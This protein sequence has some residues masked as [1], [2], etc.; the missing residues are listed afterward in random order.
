MSDIR[1]DALSLA[2]NPADTPEA[3]V[4][5]AS[6]YLAFLRGSTAAVAEPEFDAPVAEIK[7]KNVTAASTPKASTK[8]ASVEEASVEELSVATVGSGSAEEPSS[9][10]A[11]DAD[12]GPLSDE[13]IAEL[14][15]KANAAV[16]TAVKPDKLGREATIAILKAHGGSKVPEVPAEN[17]AALTAELNAKMGA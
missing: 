3:V 17:L 4:A 15:I 8:A 2:N 12:T 10:D 16:L 13:Q 5:R 9:E 11:L 1:L 14:R 6:A 7:A